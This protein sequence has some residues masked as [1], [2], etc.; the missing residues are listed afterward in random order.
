MYKV[1][2]S[3]RAKE[4]LIKIKSYISDEFDEGLSVAIMKKIISEIKNLEEYPLMGRALSNLIDVPTDYLY[5]VIEKNY[6][7][8][9]N[10]DKNVKII[11]ILSTRQ[12]FMRI[13]FGIIEIPDQ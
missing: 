7:F 5:L 10:E 8:Y 2:Y 1:M 12:D 13:L 3:P 9:R 11:R 6:M 4:D